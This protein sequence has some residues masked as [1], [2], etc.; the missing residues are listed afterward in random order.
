VE[1]SANFLFY[2]CSPSPWPWSPG[3][4]WRKLGSWRGGCTVPIYALLSLIPYLFSIHF[5]FTCS[6]VLVVCCLTKDILCLG[7]S[8]FF[9]FR[10]FSRLFFFFYLN[11]LGEM[12]LEIIMFGSCFLFFA[13]FGECRCFGGRRSKGEPGRGEQDWLH[14]HPAAALFLRRFFTVASEGLVSFV[15]SRM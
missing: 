10:L 3:G 15:C 11:L 2:F 5:V 6:R 4:D 9:L 7:G 14:W 1:F 13:T 12:V 8:C